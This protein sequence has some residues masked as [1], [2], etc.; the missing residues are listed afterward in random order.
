MPQPAESKKRALAITLKLFGEEHSN[1]ANSYHE[2]GV[3]Q[4]SQGDYA[5]A[6]ESARRALAIRLKITVWWRTFKHRR[7]LSFIRGY[8]TLTRRLCRSCRVKETCTCYQTKTVWWRTFKHRWQLSWIRGYT[9]LTRRL[10]RSCWVKPQLQ[11]QRN[12]H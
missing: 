5:A 4:H 1:T 9:T 6:A 3:T 10:C 12:V 7:Q 2:L 8:T 11:S